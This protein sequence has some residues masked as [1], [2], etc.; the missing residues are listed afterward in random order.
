MSLA[1]VKN[2]M[3]ELGFQGMLPALEGV[4]ERLHKGELHITEALDTLFEYEW[5][6]R[7]ERA[8][9]TR[10]QRSKIRRGA[11]LEEFD[12]TLS[13]GISKADLKELAKLEWCTKPLIIVGATGVG[14]SFLARSLGLLACEH[15]KTALFLAVTNVSIVSVNPA[16]P[17]QTFPQLLEAMKA[18][19]LPVA[20]AGNS[21]SGHP[22]TAR[23]FDPR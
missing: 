3:L 10:K 21:S 15:G 19:P 20:T 23:R 17:Y 11:S 22:R 2:R 12:L 14:K 18:N 7:T 5:R 4:I 1:I 8:T 16:T 13:R 6:H 9:T